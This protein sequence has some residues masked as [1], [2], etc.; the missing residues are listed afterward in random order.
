MGYAVWSFKVPQEKRFSLDLPAQP[1][2]S[3]QDDH[4]VCLG[5]L[6]SKLD[7]RNDFALYQDGEPILR[8]DGTE[9]DSWNYLG[10][11]RDGIHVFRVFTVNDR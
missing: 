10:T 9:W 7:N 3:L 2:L 1:L 6:G 11:M 4:I 5:E 8:E